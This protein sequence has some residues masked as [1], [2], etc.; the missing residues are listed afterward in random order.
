M[1][2]PNANDSPAPPV[3]AAQ[4]TNHISPSTCPYNGPTGAGSQIIM[5]PALMSNVI[6]SQM[7]GQTITGTRTMAGLSLRADKLH[8]MGT[9]MENPSILEI[10]AKST[11]A[12]RAITIPKKPHQKPILQ[13]HPMII[14]CKVR[15]T[16]S[17]HN[18]T[19][20]RMPMLIGH[21][22]LTMAMNILRITRRQM[23]S[24]LQR[25]QLNLLAKVP[26][27]ANLPPHQFH[28]IMLPAW[29]IGTPPHWLSQTRAKP[30]TWIQFLRM[31]LRHYGSVF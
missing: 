10:M 1:P 4:V 25:T 18:Q 13:S 23:P 11:M 3:P 17:I 22:F 12:V 24:L 8:T 15:A 19:P 29:E 28:W 20:I 27:I 7:V 16:T 14:N 31:A 2:A 21:L 5:Y 6:N 26:K 9:S 30:S